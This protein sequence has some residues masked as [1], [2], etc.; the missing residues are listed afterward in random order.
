M[1][2]NMVKLSSMI[3]VIAVLI[4]ISCNSKRT[5]AKSKGNGYFESKEFSFS[6][7]KEYV[8]DT[9]FQHSDV[10]KIEVHKKYAEG[11]STIITWG[12]DHFPSTIDKLVTLLVYKEMQESHT[13]YDIMSIDS[14][15]VIDGHP[16]FSIVS[17][18]TNQGNDT[19]I[20]SRTGF[21][22]KDSCNI[23]IE[24]YAKTSQEK[25]VENLSSIIK[26]FKVK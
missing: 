19:I 10:S 20:K 7:P 16:A 15:D 1:S 8:L 14:S 11:S 26:S 4:C 2:K 23:I 12:N 13:F 18:Y 3:F 6:Y 25:E 22:L 24:Q 21:T 17:I 5:I 9:I